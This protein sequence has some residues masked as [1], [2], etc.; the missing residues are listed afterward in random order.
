MNVGEQN[1]VLS[2][3]N[4]SPTPKDSFLS[5]KGPPHQSPGTIPC[6]VPGDARGM[7]T[8]YHTLNFQHIYFHT[9]LCLT[10]RAAEQIKCGSI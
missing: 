3:Q 1:L 4:L 10:E 7:A 6:E 9:S 2:L 8:Y 5:R